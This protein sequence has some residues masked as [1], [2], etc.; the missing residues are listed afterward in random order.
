MNKACHSLDTSS[1]EV[2]QQVHA[3]NCQVIHFSRAAQTNSK[4]FVRYSDCDVAS[5]VCAQE[6]THQIIHECNYTC[7]RFLCYI[8]AL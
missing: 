8:T 7:A 2:N 1:R 3:I 5:A 6:C 4:S